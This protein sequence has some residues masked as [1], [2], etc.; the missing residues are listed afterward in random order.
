VDERIRELARRS[1]N[2]GFLFD[3]EPMLVLDGASRM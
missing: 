3:L 2:L 1:A